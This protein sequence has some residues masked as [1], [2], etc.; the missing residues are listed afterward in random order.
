MKISITLNLSFTSSP[1]PF[2]PTYT[3]P[4]HL[5][6]FHEKSKS[7]RKNSTPPSPPPIDTLPPHLYPTTPPTFSALLENI[8]NFDFNFYH[9]SF[10]LPPHL[11]PATPP[12]FS[13]FLKNFMADIPTLTTPSTAYHL[14]FTLPPHLHPATPPIF[15][16]LLK[17]ALKEISTFTSPHPYPHPATPPAPCHPTYI[18]R[19]PLKSP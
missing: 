16:G 6:H 15:S 10:T 7:L 5:V 3:L 12:T 14:T 9:P 19:A 8:H 1:S 4:P 18:F 17:K 2:Q 11:Y 13:G